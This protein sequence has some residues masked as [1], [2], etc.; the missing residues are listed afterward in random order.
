MVPAL[1]GPVA[2][3]LVADGQA[4][5]QE[6]VFPGDRGAP[7]IAPNLAGLALFLRFMAGFIVRVHGWS[8][9]LLVVDLGAK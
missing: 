9:L 3:R 6:G 7:I 4:I 2:S 1:V 5:N 8:F